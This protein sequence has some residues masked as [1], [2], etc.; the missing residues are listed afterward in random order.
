[1]VIARNLIFNQKHKK[2]WAKHPALLV[3]FMIALGLGGVFSWQ[4]WVSLFSVAGTMVG[5]Y[6]M[7]KSDPW[8]MRLYIFIACMIWIPYT[9]VVHSYTGLISQ[10]VAMGAILVARIRLSGEKPE[11]ETV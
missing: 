5:T 2:K 10:L 1:M 11:I 4:G 9:L 8:K 3:L 7:W 6:G